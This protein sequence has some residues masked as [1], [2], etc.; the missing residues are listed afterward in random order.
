MLT[1][2]EIVAAALRVLYRRASDVSSRQRMTDSESVCQ[3]FAL[4][5][6]FKQTECFDVMFIDSGYRVLDVERM[7]EGTTVDCQVSPRRLIKRAL[8]LDARSV[9]I[10]HNH[11]GYDRAPSRADLATTRSLQKTLEDVDILLF[12]HVVVAGDFVYSMRENGDLGHVV[13]V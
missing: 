10:A 12:D 11:P 13:G 1:N 8:E 7:F 6:G 9:V 5:L 2:E 4:R 3:Y